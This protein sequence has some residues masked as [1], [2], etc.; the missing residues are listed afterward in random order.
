MSDNQ[1]H[2]GWR[3]NKKVKGYPDP[4]ASSNPNIIF[5]PERVDKG[6]CVTRARRERRTGRSVRAGA[7]QLL[8]LNDTLLVIFCVFMCVC[9]CCVILPYL[10]LLYQPPHV[11]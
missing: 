6:R 1:N 3:T 7:V 8:I 10:A 9:A 4:D 5:Q 2:E 11:L